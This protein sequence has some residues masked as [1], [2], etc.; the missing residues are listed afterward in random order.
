MSK[1]KRK[2][3]DHTPMTL[4]HIPGT[5]VLSRL[6]AAPVLLWAALTGQS[7]FWLIGILVYV[8]LSDVFDGVIARRLQVVTARLRVADSWADTL[9]YVCVALAVWRLHRALLGP[10]LIPLLIVMG[11]MSVNWAVAM[12]KFRRAM[13]FHAYSSKLWGLSL[14][15]ASV[16]L[17]GFSHAGG[18]LW[19]VIAVGIAGHLEGFVMTLILPRWAHEVSGIP[20]ALRLRAEARVQACKPSP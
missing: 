13:S 6:L 17:L 15:A 11:L 8:F 16:S 7:R 20:E 5:L 10:F 4:H 18:F 1:A 14:F 9:F 12:L 2:P 3:E 19:A